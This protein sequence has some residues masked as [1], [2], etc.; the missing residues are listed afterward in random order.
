MKKNI[1][2]KCDGYE[3]KIR[4][5]MENSKREKDRKEYLENEIINTERAIKDILKD[6]DE[7]TL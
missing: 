5:V 7:L 2:A 3:I 4:D 6:Y 1:K